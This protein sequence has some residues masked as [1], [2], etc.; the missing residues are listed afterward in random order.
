[1]SPTMPGH[2]SPIDHQAQCEVLGPPKSHGD[3][4]N[5]GR[6]PRPK[7]RVPTPPVEAR[8]HGKMKRFVAHNAAPAALALMATKSRSMIQPVPLR[9]FSFQPS[10]SPTGSAYFANPRPHD[11]KPHAISPLHHTAGLPFDG[12]LPRLSRMRVARICRMRRA[13]MDE[14]PQDRGVP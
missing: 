7:C 10:L 8:A 11:V 1:L 4:T 2:I 5:E 6:R 13:R 9:R 3:P 12:G 14:L